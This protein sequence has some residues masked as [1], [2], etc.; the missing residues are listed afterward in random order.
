MP[1]DVR[2]PFD[3]DLHAAERQTKAYAEMADTIE[4]VDLLQCDR[5]QESGGAGEQDV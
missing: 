5:Y 2:G 1:L 4:K 3:H